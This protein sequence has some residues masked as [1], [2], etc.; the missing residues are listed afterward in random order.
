MI[1]SDE[2]RV[3]MVSL[4]PTIRGAVRMDE[5]GFPSIYIN[6]SLSPKA[7]KETFL[8]EIR[9]IERADHTSRKSIRRVEADA[10]QA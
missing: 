2:Y 1:D 8:H 7:R 10:A 3:Y 4:P 9:H 5:S 6:D